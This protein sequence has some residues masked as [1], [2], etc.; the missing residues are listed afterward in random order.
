MAANTT[1]R[2]QSAQ[3]IT[4]VPALVAGNFTA[5]Q[6]VELNGWLA[7]GASLGVA[8]MVAGVLGYINAQWLTRPFRTLAEKLG[9]IARG[10]TSLDS[11]LDLDSS[12]DSLAQTI[13]AE[14]HSVLNNTALNLNSLSAT[15]NELA[16]TAAKMSDVTERTE[17]NTT[18]QQ[19][20]TDLV[21]TAMS[22]MSATVEEVARNT[23]AASHA[24]Q[25]AKNAAQ[26]GFSIA[27][28][29]KRG[30]DTLVGDIE[31]AAQV[32]NRLEEESKNI[33]MV[34]DVIKSIAEQT[35]LL[36]LNAAIEAARAREQGRGFAV[37]ADEVRTLASRTQ[38][39][40]HEIEEIIERLRNGARESVSVMQV[41]LEKG[42]I[43]SKQVDN[44]L[45]ALNGISGS[46]GKITDMNTQIAS[47]AEEQSQ[48][49]NEISRNIENISQISQLTNQDA[50]ESH[51]TSEK[52]ADI[53]SKLKTLLDKSNISAK[54]GL[55]LSSAKAAHLNWKTKLRSFL[56]GKASLTREQAVSHRHCDFG[57]WYYSDG[58]SKFGHIKAIR[59][60]EDPHKQLHDLIKKIVD[61]K[62]NGQLKEA[63]RVYLNVGMLSDR[64]VAL[65][66]D[67]EKQAK[68]ER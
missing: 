6:I 1:T 68:S 29:T 27:Q 59:E 61:L 25:Q 51:E 40:T 32:I 4:L 52:L 54:S 57:K 45:E 34:L 28:D 18:K 53:S 7:I 5:Y 58:K 35:N 30:I 33:G 49:A 62:N 20:E 37:V 11:R 41:A 13:G 66:N 14:L 63:E 46:V 60:V 44:T 8:T 16:F 64:I 56:D 38:E 10:K 9:N 3:I 36:A 21:A 12:E 48:V 39:S 17:T 22:E 43:G 42:Q 47:A 19:N 2:I 31:N 65:L 24:A 15:T 67:A 55:D 23:Q 50:R 26:S